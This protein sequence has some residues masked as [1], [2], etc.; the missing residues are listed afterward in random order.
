MDMS[1]IFQNSSS[2]RKLEYL[3]MGWISVGKSV[4]PH[5]AKEGGKAER[6]RSG[7]KRNRSSTGS[8]G[9]GTELVEVDRHLCTKQ[10]LGVTDI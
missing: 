3:I 9:D 2:G 1:N 10:W 5:I 6:C 4:T 7:T 8:S